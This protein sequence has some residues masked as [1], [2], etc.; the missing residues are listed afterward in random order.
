VDLQVKRQGHVSPN[1]TITHILTRLHQYSDGFS[2]LAALCEIKIG[3]RWSPRISTT[4][5]VIMTGPEACNRPSQ[6]DKRTSFSMLNVTYTFRY[7][8]HNN[9]RRW[10]RFAVVRSRKIW[11]CIGPPKLFISSKRSLY[12]TRLSAS[13]FRKWTTST[14]TS[15]FIRICQ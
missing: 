6:T 1:F 7:G 3:G 10:L 11:F 14:K 9:D 12:I 13:V 4:P 2:I 8:G 15:I 5:I